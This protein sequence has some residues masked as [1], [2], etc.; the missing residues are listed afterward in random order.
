[1]TDRVHGTSAGAGPTPA[2]CGCVLH[3][4][5]GPGSARTAYKIY[6]AAEEGGEGGG[7]EDQTLAYTVNGLPHTYDTDR[8]IHWTPRVDVLHS[9][10]GVR[11]VQ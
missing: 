3:G 11:F 9:L 1:M 10:R 8:A 2:L 6:G 7:Y 5:G 4:P